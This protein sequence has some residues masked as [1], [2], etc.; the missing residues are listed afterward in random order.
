MVIIGPTEGNKLQLWNDLLM[1]KK[2]I[3]TFKNSSDERAR[4]IYNV[5]LGFFSRRLSE[6]ANRAS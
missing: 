6:Y 5:D 3:E 4:Q 2:S 1:S